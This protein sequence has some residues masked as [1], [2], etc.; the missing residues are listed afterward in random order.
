MDIE[1]HIRDRRTELGRSIAVRKKVYLDAR[2]WIIVRDASLGLSASA[3]ERKLLDI[4]RVG[5]TRGNL[6]CPISAAMFLELMKQ[7]CRP[8]RRI[9]TAELI[10]ELSQGVS[11]VPPKRLAGTEI[12]WLILRL[13][14]PNADLFPMQELIWTKVSYTLGNMYPLVVPELSPE[15]LHHLQ[16]SL[17]DFMWGT[18][19]GKIIQ[20]IDEQPDI[21]SFEDLSNEVNDDCARF[22]HELRSFKCTYDIEVRGAAEASSALAADVIVPLR[23]RLW[24]YAAPDSRAALQRCKNRLQYSLPRDAAKRA[25]RRATLD[26]YRSLAARCHAMGQE[27]QVQTE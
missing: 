24:P 21:G 16:V 14:Q 18:P 13:M 6:I 9:A 19:L 12:H 5:V 23:E 11:I 25:S 20:N 15:E 1:R 7:P 17:I 26:A 22:K 4:L 3:A 8:E 2:F 10:D 27:A